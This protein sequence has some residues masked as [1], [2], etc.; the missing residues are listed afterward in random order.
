MKTLSILAFL[1]FLL[2][3]GFSARLGAVKLEK[4]L[5]FGSDDKRDY[6]FFGAG[7]ITSDHDGNIFVFDSGRCVIRKYNQKGVFVKEA[8]KKG[9]GPEEFLG[10]SGIVVWKDSL[11]IYDYINKRLSQYDFDLEFIKSEK[12]NYAFSRGMECN[13]DYLFF[14]RWINLQ[15]GLI[16]VPPFSEEKK[17]ITP[18]HDFGNL[19]K[20]RTS[21]LFFAFFNYCFSVD[22]CS[23][24]IVV[25]LSAPLT[26]EPEL[27]SY[28]RKGE[29]QSKIKMERIANYSFDERRVDLSRAGQVRGKGS[30]LV[31]I[32]AFHAAENQ[33]VFSYEYSG[34]IGNPETVE[35]GLL[36]V[37]TNDGK[38]LGRLKSKEY[39]IRC[40]QNGLAYGYIRD[41]EDA[42][43]KVGVY[44]IVL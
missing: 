35:A 9:Q 36:L 17:L 28:N 16:M 34:I 43:L 41:A 30:F 18:Q 25:T 4:V 2:S 29:L 32:R 7:P 1:L 22:P 3:S 12:L 20:F 15:G 37:D 23:G 31:L 26:G 40:I 14:N 11:L 27:F 8:G 42:E 24:G 5:E 6:L 39:D 19:K 21:P 10:V 44:R 33:V 38:I 13:Q